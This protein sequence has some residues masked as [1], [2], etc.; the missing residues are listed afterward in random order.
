MYLPDFWLLDAHILA[1][2]PM[3][4][5]GI[6]GN[7]KYDRRKRDKIRGYEEDLR[8]RGIPY[9]YWDV[10]A[11]DECELPVFPARVG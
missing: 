5:F 3:E 9:W 10:D 7:E 4:I 6:R 8:E 1:R 11:M 2:V